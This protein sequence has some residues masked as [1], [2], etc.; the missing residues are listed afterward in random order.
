MN[1]IMKLIVVVISLST[2]CFSQDTN[3]VSFAVV[4]TYGYVSPIFTYKNSQWTNFFD[5]SDEY[6]RIETWFFTPFRQSLQLKVDST[7]HRLGHTPRPH[8]LGYKSNLRELY[9]LRDHNALGIASNINLSFSNFDNISPNTETW[10]KIFN[11]T[12]KIQIPENAPYLSS[13]YWSKYFTPNNIATFSNMKLF[14]TTL[15]SV[16]IYYFEMNQTFGD[17]H[18]PSYL[19]SNGWIIYKDSGFRIIDQF[20]GLDDCDFKMLSN[21][22]TTPLM[23]FYLFDKLLVFVEKSQWE[24]QAYAIY[25]IY[26]DTL[27]LCIIF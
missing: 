15:D 22:P 4:D 9:N 10:E 13:E 8:R 23:G 5:S 6:N 1:N 12:S 19:F 25:E 21:R 17:D 3:S 14:E 7:M 24:G 20:V 26:P 2:I 16:S 27:K 11:L 18:C